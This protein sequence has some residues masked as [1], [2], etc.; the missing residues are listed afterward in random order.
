MYGHHRHIKCVV[1]HIYLYSGIPYCHIWLYTW[2]CITVRGYTYIFTLKASLYT[3]LRTPTLA[4]HQIWLYM[5]L[6]YAMPGY[7]LNA[8]LYTFLCTP[9]FH[10]AIYGYI[11]G[12]A[13]WCVAIRIFF[14]LKASVY[15]VLRTPALT[16]HHV[17]THMVIPLHVWLYIKHMV[18]HI[19]LYSNIPL[20][21]MRLY[22]W[23]C[24]MV[25]SYTRNFANV[26]TSYTRMS[27]F[28]T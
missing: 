7:T 24:I 27:S 14:T 5:L 10:F 18:I 6:Y 12:Y 17:V 28:H 16:L 8:W 2:L 3:V 22:T 15:T 26:T 25:Y 11:R 4:L 13:S 1:I 21:H 20:Y 9:A 19:Y 23:L